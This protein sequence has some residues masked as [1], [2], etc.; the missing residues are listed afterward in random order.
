MSREVAAL[1]RLY[2]DRSFDDYTPATDAQR[3]AL[4]AMQ[5]LADGT[6][7]RLGVYLAVDAIGRALVTLADGA[8]RVASGADAAAAIA[9]EAAI[10]DLAPLARTPR[11][12]GSGHD[13]ASVDG[14]NA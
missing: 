11:G 3:K 14:A 8:S 6:L 10:A 5:G 1:P 2:Q 7:R 4:A 12:G 13:M 9:T